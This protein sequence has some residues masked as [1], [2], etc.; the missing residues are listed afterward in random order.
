MIN[1]DGHRTGQH[2]EMM[3]LHKMS[4]DVK[5]VCI[6]TREGLNDVAIMVSAETAKISADIKQKLWHEGLG[7]CRN[8][9]LLKSLLYIQGVN[10]P[11]TG[12]DTEPCRTCFF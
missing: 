7:H 12:K 4:G 5:K 8:D 11:E 3:L 1:D 9:N 6:E 10:F 2:G